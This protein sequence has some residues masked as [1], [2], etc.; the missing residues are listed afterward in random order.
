MTLGKTFG[1]LGILTSIK[2]FN[3]I[4]RIIYQFAMTQ[5]KTNMIHAIIDQKFN[6]QYSA[7]FG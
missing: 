2:K 6:F 1:K 3:N 5:L 4:F 7:K